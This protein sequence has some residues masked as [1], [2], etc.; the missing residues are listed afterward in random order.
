LVRDLGGVWEEIS[1]T[2]GTN[3][4]VLIP[5]SL[6]LEPDAL[7]AAGSV[8]I[9]SLARILVVEDHPINQQVILQMLDRMG[10]QADLAEDG[11][12]ALSLWEDQPYPLIFMDCHL[13]G[14]SGIDAASVIREREKNTGTH[15][16]IV[17]LTADAMDRTRSLCFAAG[18]EDFLSKPLFP[19]DLLRVLNKYLPGYSERQAAGISRPP[20]DE[21]R[22]R[23]LSWRDGRSQD[24]VD[25][26]VEATNAGFHR[27]EK[28][29]SARDFGSMEKE[30]REL[31]ARFGTEDAVF[32]ERECQFLGAAV[33]AREIGRILERKEMLRGDWRETTSLLNSLQSA[34]RI[35]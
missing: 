18:M 25:L 5:F 33:E 16:V 29:W 19:E 7:S 1:E 2:H 35:L 34:Y 6:P 12:S 21:R 31:E 4:R 28:A 32:L 26:F 3:I 8:S 22:A 10:V 23:M 15:S 27:L 9:D 30:I 20:P 11:E 13:P 17:A 24:S 14:I